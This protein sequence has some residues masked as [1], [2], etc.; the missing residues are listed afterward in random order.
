[1]EMMRGGT[2]LAARALAYSWICSIGGVS[3]L[4]YMAWTL[5][6]AKDVSIQ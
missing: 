3:I 6:G 5:S 1:M 2:R 4:V